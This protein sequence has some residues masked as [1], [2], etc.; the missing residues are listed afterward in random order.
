MTVNVNDV[1]IPILDRPY[2]TFPIGS[3]SN[4]YRYPSLLESFFSL[5]ASVGQDNY[6]RPCSAATC[7]VVFCRALRTAWT[8]TGYKCHYSH[9][10]AKKPLLMWA[11]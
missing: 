1:R 11:G 6:V 2:R 8:Q 3:R 5:T 9:V 4:E 7:A 10:T